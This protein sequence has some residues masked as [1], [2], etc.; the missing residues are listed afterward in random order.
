[1]INLRNENWVVKHIEKPIYLMVNHKWAFIIWE[2]NKIKKFIKEHAC[3]VHVDTHL[4]DV[5]ELVLN[6][7]VILASTPQD[8]V[9]IVNYEQGEDRYEPEL[10]MD[11]F[12]IPSF[13]RGTIQDII[14]VSNPEN[15]KEATTKEITVEDM[16]EDANELM[17]FKCFE[18]INGQE[19]SISRFMGVQDFI[20]K[21]V[22]FKEK[23]H[24]ILDLDLDYFNNSLLY[25]T[26]DLKNEDVIFSDLAALKAYTDWDLI[27]VALSPDF[28][29]ED[30]DCLYLL[31]L[32]LEVFDLNLSEFKVW[33]I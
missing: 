8:L 19:K 9:D 11:N 31:E 21:T 7:N 5:P 22:S 25:R 20:S 26:A 33:S 6:Q 1:M 16:S 29:G 14:Y 13:L 10:R 18:L 12:I 15:K 24:E 2:Y 27:T 23:Q 4:D 17:L 30:Q 28:C 3:L 32:F